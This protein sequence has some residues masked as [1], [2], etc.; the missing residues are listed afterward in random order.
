MEGFTG[1]TLLLARGHPNELTMLTYVVEAPCMSPRLQKWNQRSCLD[2]MYFPGV[3]LASGECC[4]D[5]PSKLTAAPLEKE[6]RIRQ[7]N[8]CKWNKNTQSYGQCIFQFH[9]PLFKKWLPCSQLI[10]KCLIDS[11]FL[12]CFVSFHW[13][14]W[15]SV[16]AQNE[17]MVLIICRIT[18]NR[19]DGKN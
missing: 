10:L 11:C 16:E 1:K 12:K 6:H 4:D 9:P 5:C 7:H 19:K 14:L 18:Y 2:F 13:F 3:V 17:I 8:S 15:A